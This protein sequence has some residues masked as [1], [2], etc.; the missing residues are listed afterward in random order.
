MLERL[1]HSKVISVTTTVELGVEV[2]YK[3]VFSKGNRNLTQH[4]LVRILLC[5]IVV[6]LCV[7]TEALR[8]ELC[9]VHC[10]TCTH[11]VMTVTTLRDY[12]KVTFTKL[13]EQITSENVNDHVN[14]SFVVS[15]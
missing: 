2:S 12:I 15:G 13:C 7:S 3:A 1:C 5:V 9:K 4:F 10:D 14:L 8:I 11:H 6:C